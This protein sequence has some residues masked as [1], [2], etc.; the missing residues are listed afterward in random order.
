MQLTK[1]GTIAQALAGATCA[2][3]GL[4]THAG[5]PGSWDFDT[6]VLYYGEDNGRVQALEPVVAATRYFADERQLGIKLTIDSLTG[7]SPNGAT[8]SD[9]PQT[10][11]RPSG[12]GVYTIA[13]GD[14]PLDDTFKDTRGALNVG[15]SSPINSDWRYSTGF[16]VSAEHDYFSTG[17]NGSITRYLNDKNTELTLGLAAASDT[18]KPVG[19]APK[20]LV[21][22]TNPGDTN[23]WT[24][25][26]ATRQG[27]SDSKTLTDALIGVTQV[28]NK[29]TIMQFNYSL[30]SST[31]YLTDPYKLLSVIDSTTGNT[32]VDGSGA[33]IYVYEQRPDSRT[34]HAFFWQTKYM[35]E[36]G[37]VIDGSYRFMTDDWG[38]ASH[39]IDLKYHWQFDHA[40]LEP[41]VRYYMQSEADF[42]RRYALNTDYN[43]S[44]QKLNLSDASADY[45][46]GELTG[47]TVGVKYARQFH[48]QEFSVRAEYFLQSNSG[49]KGVG[50]LASQELY[51]DT[52]AV[53]VTLG[54]SF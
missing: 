13:P 8:S 52:N 6:A 48:E 21:R 34:K 50:A 49:D 23:F 37:D 27:D 18:I 12:K 36:S 38:I 4:S 45:R 33:P 17:L 3:L 40:Y 2:L 7:A 14:A 43:S 25:F 5:E 28:I 53:M 35:L 22:V 51:P 15:W 20:G 9:R 32:A 42:Y 30:S 1:P 44:T 47:T 11:T 19:G 54:Y 39:T 10:F 16:N 24:K 41:H 29:R 26:D 46:L 31:G